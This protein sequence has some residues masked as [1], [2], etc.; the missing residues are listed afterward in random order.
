MEGAQIGGALLLVL[1][2]LYVPGA[3]LVGVGLGRSKREALAGGPAVSV[4]LLGVIG[5]VL[6]F[7][8]VR[9]STVTILTGVGIVVAG[10][11]GVGRVRRSWSLRAGSPDGANWL[12]TIAGAAAG[13]VVAAIAWGP[14]GQWVTAPP[15]LWDYLWH[16]YVVATM[17]RRGV[18][19]PQNLV[20]V[21]GYAELTTY[22]QHGAHLIAGSIPG[23]GVEAVSAGL[24]LTLWAAAVLVLPL[25]LA[26]LAGAFRATPMAIV[27]APVAAAIA[28]D[29]VFGQFDLWAFAVALCLTPGV[30]YTGVSFIRA[31]T[32]SSAMTVVLAL[33]GLLLVHPHGYVIASVAMGAA[34]LLL[35]EPG[36]PD[37]RR[38]PARGVPIA[39]M[40]CGALG[41]ALTLPWYL[42]ANEVQTFS[43]TLPLRPAGFDGPGEVLRHM[44]LGQRVSTAGP[45]SAYVLLGVGTW[46]A[47]L[48]L[49][50]RRRH[51]AV[52]LAWSVLVAMTL[53]T[54]GGSGSVRT[55][56]G[57]L[58]LGDWYRPAAGYSLLGSLVL[59]LGIDELVTS[60][61]PTPD[62]RALA[63]RVAGVLACVLLVVA[64][65][66]R[67]PDARADVARLYGPWLTPAAEGR[68]DGPGDASGRALASE[69]APVFGPEQ[70][71]AL[72]VLA[73]VTPAGT[74]VMNW[75]PDGSPWMY[76]AYGLVP[77]Q[78]YAI[79][80]IDW[81]DAVLVQRHLH[82]VERYDEVIEA[83]GR[84]QV[85]TAFAA[86]GHL[87]AGT[88]PTW[89][90]LEALPGFVLVHQD[91]HGR[92][93][94][95]DDPRLRA[96]C[97]PG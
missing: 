58:W 8:G 27:I 50:V 6:G 79:T 54:A 36:T 56:I 76:G 43:T 46:A 78:T 85:C 15:Q 53:V 34:L 89:T 10:S 64:I 44:L 63:G 72:R 82:D 90:Q 24:N 70:A 1:F 12:M 80:S 60:L 42:L 40:L 47:A 84:L 93:F 68:T 13:G 29:L 4:L 74:R 33:A 94:S 86:E 51:L 19:G 95:A 32:W 17:Q 35:V 45:E 88:R 67:I 16:Q 38:L 75:W 65:T 22:Y 69:E 5:G 28:P 57:G 91:A 39:L 11:V 23:E 62:R 59:A 81:S 48:L 87:D 55:V 26:V 52:L 31:R 66:V 3:A 92:V 18:L 71:A 30:I 21:D 96:H 77:V 20:P 25:G 9:A 73:A 83:L 37:S 7:L 97:E 2:L 61:S 41:V 49:A 14:M